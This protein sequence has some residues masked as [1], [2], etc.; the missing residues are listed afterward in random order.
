TTR[1]TWPSTTPWSAGTPST[2]STAGRGSVPGA[3]VSRPS[4]GAPSSTCWPPGPLLWA[5]RSVTG[6]WV[7]PTTMPSPATA[8]EWAGTRSAPW[9]GGRRLLVNEQQARSNLWAT[10][11]TLRNRS[12]HHGRTVL[13]GDAAHTAH[14]SIGSG[15]RLALDDAIA[16]AKAFLA[17]PGDL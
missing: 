12:W 9:L 14:F 2:S 3:T 16:L 1:P 4:P 17:H 8:W 6:Q 13:L 7:C 10:F 11:A 5:P 15:T